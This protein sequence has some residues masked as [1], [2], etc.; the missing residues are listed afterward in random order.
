MQM[1]MSCCAWESA[2]EQNPE[3]HRLVP[4]KTMLLK[5]T[6]QVP[7]NCDVPGWINV[8]FP[9][10]CNVQ[11]FT[12]HDWN[13]ITRYTAQANSHSKGSLFKLSLSLS[14]NHTNIAAV[15]IAGWISW[16]SINVPQD[17]QKA[18]NQALKTWF[19]QWHSWSHYQSITEVSQKENIL[20]T[21]HHSLDWV[22]SRDDIDSLGTSNKGR[23][24][25][26]KAC[27]SFN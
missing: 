2:G 24:T 25:T 4:P 27:V 7:C 3:E 22:L 15:T 26:I 19:G 21:Q 8:L 1:S 5:A 23:L 10:N 11:H 13:I 16:P 9:L 18:H 6:S 17:Y 14:P 20:V 12:E